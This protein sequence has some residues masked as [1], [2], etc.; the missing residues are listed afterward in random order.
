MYMYIY[1]YIYSCRVRS[2]LATYHK[3]LVVLNSC[4]LPQGSQIWFSPTLPF[5]GHSFLYPT[6]RKP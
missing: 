1:I 5:R 4:R 6:C 3:D 2:F